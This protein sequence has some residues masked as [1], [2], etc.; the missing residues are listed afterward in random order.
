MLRELYY[1]DT[2]L[3]WHEI[4]EIYSILFTSKGYYFFIE[5]GLV[6]NPTREYPYG[7]QTLSGI[8]H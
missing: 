3:R 8:T 2:I 6:K 5:S 7:E 1:L 4:D